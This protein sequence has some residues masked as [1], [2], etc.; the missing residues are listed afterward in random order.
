MDL[1]K[2]GTAAYPLPWHLFSKTGVLGDPTVATSEKGEKWL[3]AAAERLVQLVK[4]FKRVSSE[5]RPPSSR[6]KPK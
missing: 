3:D 2:A 6:R 5:K 4:E 1:G